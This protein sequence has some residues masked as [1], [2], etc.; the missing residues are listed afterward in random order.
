MALQAFGG[1]R[2]ILPDGTRT[3]G[4][5]HMLLVGDPGTAKSQLLIYMSK[6]VP[7]SLFTAG[8][9]ST[10]VGLTAAAVK[11][12]FSEGWTLEAGTLVLADGSL[13][14]VDELDKMDERDREAMHQALEQQ[15]ISV[16]K[17]GINATLKAR[18]S[19][20][21]AANP[22]LGR[23]DEFIP[24]Y[25]QI[26][27]PPALFSRFDL[28]FPIIDKPKKDTDE[29]LAEHMLRLHQNPEKYENA[30]PFFFA[31]F[32]RKYIAYARQNS[33]P[34]LTDDALTVIKE[35]FVDIREKSIKGEVPVTPRQLETLMR[36]SEASAR[37]RLD[38]E[39][40]VEDA[41]RAIAI[42]GEYARRVATDRE[43]GGIDLDI[44]ATGHSHSQQGRMRIIIGIIDRLSKESPDSWA[45]QEDIVREAEI[46]GIDASKTESALKH[47]EQERRVEHHSGKYRVI[48]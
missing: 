27:L 29:K 14:C 26:N 3:R 22:K 39:I 2:K 28:I 6:L 44:I 24:L 11:D 47:L 25:E 9:S 19:L 17:A 1:V 40:T 42:F 10:G 31:D 13:A 7:G 38:K 46:K 23:F 36:L 15:E 16:A 45:K 21:A 32:L 18:C 41:E 4:D 5:I 12:E 33:K 34:V 43:T 37:I 8:P 20:L 30:K 48:A 35:F